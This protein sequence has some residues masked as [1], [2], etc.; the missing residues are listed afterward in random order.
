MKQLIKNEL[1][2]EL[3]TIDEVAF[4]EAYHNAKGYNKDE[5]KQ[6]VKSVLVQLLEKNANAPHKT[7][8]GKFGAFMSKIGA[9]ILPFVKLNRKL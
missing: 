8:F 6:A 7:R 3:G 2:Q 9:V 1:L 5:I 4:D